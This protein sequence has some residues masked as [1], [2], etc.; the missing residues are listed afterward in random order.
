MSSINHRQHRKGQLRRRQRWER[1]HKEWRR[2]IVGKAEREGWGAKTT[3][4]TTTSLTAAT[5]YWDWYL[6]TLALLLVIAVLAAVSRY[7]TSTGTANATATST[8]ANRTINIDPDFVYLPG[9]VFSGFWYTLG[10]L[11]SSSFK[12]G[13]SDNHRRCCRLY[14]C[15]RAGCLSVVASLPEQGVQDVLNAKDRVS[16]GWTR[17]N[18]VWYN[19]VPTFVDDMLLLKTTTTTTPVN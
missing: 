16:R 17:R 2:D 5:P 13:V 3:T 11:P 1:L 12:S 7:L 9:S 19:V 6:A 4:T 14:H 10:R 18:I 15:Y 8:A